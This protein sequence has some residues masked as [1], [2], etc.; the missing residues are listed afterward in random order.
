[1]IQFPAVKSNCPI[2]ISKEGAGKGTL[3]KVLLKLLGVNKYYETTEPERDVWGSFNSLMS[4]CYLVNLNELS[5]KSTN[6]SMGKI[7]G[8]IVDGAMTIN[9]KG[10]TP[11]KTTSYHRFIITTNSE[12]PMP[13]KKDDRRFWIVRSSDELIG[14]K[15]YFDDMQKIIQDDNAITSIFQYFKTLEGAEDFNKL[16]RPLTEFQQNIQEANISAPERWLRDYVSDCGEE[17]TTL[18]GKEI[19]QKFQAWKDTNGITFEV[20]A[21]KLGLALSNMNIDGIKKGQHT[22][23]GA[24]K[25]FEIKKI[26]KHFGVGCLIQLADNEESEDEE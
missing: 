8:L 21:I 26:R 24:T 7:K 11:Y 1:M 13:T 19:Y 6:D 2:L 10:I 22:N 17:E 20:N 4:E 14:N 12:D 15:A 3:L 18:S 25:I 23:K 9:P 5:K 16:Q